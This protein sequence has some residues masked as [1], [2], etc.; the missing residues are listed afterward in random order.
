MRRLRRGAGLTQAAMAEMLAISPSYLNLV[1]RNQRPL[2]ASV[3]LR[4]AEAFD[5]DPRTLS[6]S[7]PGGGA[8]AIRRRLA[9]PIFAD[10]EIDRHQMEEWLAGAP[11]GAEAFARAYDRIGAGAAEESGMPD[12]HGQVRREIERWRNHFADLD[13]AAEALADELRMGAGDPYGAMAERLR[14]KHQLSVRILPADVLG[15]NLKRLDMHARQLQLSE[16]LDASARV[17]ALAEQLAWEARE[18]I[19]ALVRGA[20]L[21]RMSERLFRRHLTGYFA[22]AVMMPYARF[23]RACEATGYDA[24]ILQRR[25]GASFSQVAHRL[26]TLQRVGA[27]GLPF[28]MLRV[29]RAGQVSKRYAG[30]SG[31]PLAEGPGVCPLWDVFAAFARADVAVTDLVETEDGGRWFTLARCVTPQGTGQ[32][33]ARFAIALG[34]D[35]AEAGTLAAARGMD[36]RGRAT[37]VGLGCRAC[38]RVDCPQR[39]APPAGRALVMSERESGVTPLGFAAD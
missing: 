2:T 4:M 7:E 1:E 38:T 10:L 35:A 26:T 29:D 3:L 30:A 33:Q 12:P 21:E 13:V 20:G 22:A 28:F 18:Q 34:L 19:D 32:V 14:V 37:P 6:A 17:F 16:M 27:R 11:G 5:F 23:L 8:E 36:L 24:D 39:S 31:S 9:D 25:F 15:G